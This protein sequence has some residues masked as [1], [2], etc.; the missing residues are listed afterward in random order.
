MCI[1]LSLQDMPAMPLALPHKGRD[2]K[3]LGFFAF[4]MRRACRMSY[5]S[6]SDTQE[7]NCNRALSNL[8]LILDGRWQ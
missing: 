2:V 5:H 4:A 6:M 1:F 7:L 3:K 8:K